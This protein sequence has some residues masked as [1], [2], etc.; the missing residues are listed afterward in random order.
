MGF[1][2]SADF[3]TPILDRERNPRTR[4]D[5]DENDGAVVYV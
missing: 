1:L 5:R 3:A 4:A 2:N